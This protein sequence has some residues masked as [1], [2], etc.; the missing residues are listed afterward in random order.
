MNT[1]FATVRSLSLSFFRL[2]VTRTGRTT[3]PILTLYMSWRLPPK[4]MPFGSF[5]D[6]L[7]YLGSQIPQNANFGGMNRYFQAKWAK[8]KIMYI[9][10]ITAP[11]PTKF[12]TMIK[13]TKCSSRVVQTCAKQI[14][15]DAWL[16]YWNKS[17]AI[18]EMGD[19]L[20]TIGMGRKWGG[21]AVGGWVPT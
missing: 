18:S 4:D 14:Q 16:P 11:I 3:G 19:C 2:L 21:A 7:P 20:A 12:C 1:Q 15:H 17:S 5:A 13:T 10:E 6:M 9:I 8:S